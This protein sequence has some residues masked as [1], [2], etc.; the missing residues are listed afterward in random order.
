[1]LRKA[2]ITAVP[3]HVT[4]SS[5]SVVALVGE[6]AAYVK[7]VA[8]R[9]CAARRRLFGR[10]QRAAQARGPRMARAQAALAATVRVVR[11]RHPIH[12][13]AVNRAGRGAAGRSTT[14]APASRQGG[15]VRT[16]STSST[17]SSS[18]YST[19]TGGPR[20]SGRRAQG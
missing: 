4:A 20:R 2:A 3:Q 17:S 13:A 15:S 19:P 14:H 8:A 6:V 18:S 1:M 9:R 5:P 7:P 16:Y 11:R 10:R 12:P